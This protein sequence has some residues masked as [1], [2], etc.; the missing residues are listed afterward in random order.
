M[1]HIYGADRVWL[2]RLVGRPRSAMFDPGESWTLASLREAW[3][4][5]R[6]QWVEW[7]DSVEDPR[8][9][10]SYQNLSGQ[11]FQV[12]LWQVVFHVVNHA[13]YHRGQIT[14]M[15]RQLGYSPVPTDLHT[16]Y[17]TAAK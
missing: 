9:R 1:L 10:L 11:P 15:L 2:S 5:L 6:R 13:T 8:A 7:V 3:R 12:E 17:L 14:T 16:F 4:E